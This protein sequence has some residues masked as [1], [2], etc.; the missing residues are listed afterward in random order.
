MSWL[1]RAWLCLMVIFSGSAAAI[2][3]DF[4]LTADDGTPYSLRDS[5]GQTVILSFGY[6]FCPDVCPTGLA[7]VAQALQQLGDEADKVDA[8]FVSL[9]PE[10]DTPGHL[11]EYTRFFHPQLRGLTGEEDQL[12][13]VADRYRVRY[14]FVGKG[15][16]PHYSMDHSANLYI[17]NPRGRLFRILP[18]GLPP[19]AIVNGL[20][21]AM[22]SAPN[23][24]GTRPQG[25]RKGS[26]LHTD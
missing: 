2:G 15:E 4:T 7:T 23:Y 14:A 3:G 8:F 11:R 9:D 26:L 21:A 24:S 12:K 16:R 1:A 25:P 5:R 10:R 6:T 22:A 20:R 19:R 13:E 17:V 18:H